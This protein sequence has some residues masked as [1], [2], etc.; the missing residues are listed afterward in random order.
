MNMK[1]IIALISL[2]GVI[3]CTLA[4]M[5]YQNQWR[6]FQKAIDENKVEDAENELTKIT[7][8]AMAHHDEETIFR[9]AIEQLRL[10]FL[11]AEDSYDVT[12]QHLDSIIALQQYQ[13]TPYAQL[14]NLTKAQFLQMYMQDN[15]G[16]IYQNDAYIRPESANILEW[17]QQKFKQSIQS[18]Y[19]F[20]LENPQTLVEFAVSEF[21]YLIDTNV[22]MRYLRPSIYDLIMQNY[23]EYLRYDNQLSYQSVLDQTIA[24][25]KKNYPSKTEIIVD[26]E[27]MYLESLAYDDKTLYMRAIDSLSAKY[28]YQPGWDA[29]IYNKAL[30]LYQY[31]MTYDFTDTATICFKNDLKTS[32]EIFQTLKTQTKRAYLKN[33]ADY[34][35]QQ[36]KTRKFQIETIKRMLPSNT[37]MLLP[38]CY[39]NMDSIYIHIYKSVNINPYWGA[40]ALYKH[41]Y[42]K[43]CPLVKSYAYKLK[44]FK[45]Y[46]QHKTDL[47][48]DGLP[49]GSYYIVMTLL[50]EMQPENRDGEIMEI[51]VTDINIVYQ[52]DDKNIKLTVLDRKT[53]MPKIKA[54]VKIIPKKNY[55]DQAKLMPTADYL[56][57]YKGQIV[58]GK[59]K[60][61]MRG[62]FEVVYQNDSLE[63]S[64]F[65]TITRDDQLQEVKSFLITDR[66]IYRP[67][68]FVF[69]KGILYNDKNKQVLNHRTITVYLQNTHYKIIDSLKLDISDFG[70]FYGQFQLPLTGGTGIY[71]LKVNE[72][73]TSFH[74]E[75]YKRPNFEVNINKIDQ[76]YILGENIAVTG[77]AQAY[78]GYPIDHATV[79]YAVTVASV[80][81][82]K[83]YVEPEFQLT[84]GTINTDQ[85]GHFTFE[86][87]S[88]ADFLKSGKLYLYKITV[89]VTDINGETQKSETSFNLGNQSLFLNMDN[90]DVDKSL[91]DSIVRV[92]QVVNI[93]GE[94]VRTNIRVTVEQLK[95]PETY[96]LKREDSY[97]DCPIMDERQYSCSF[98]GKDNQ[99]LVDIS[100]WKVMKQLYSQEISTDTLSQTVWHIK[101]WKEGMYRVVLEA[102]DKYN[103]SVK[104]TFYWNLYNTNTSSMEDYRPLVVYVSDN[105]V[106]VGE[107]LKLTV[108]SYLKKAIVYYEVKSNGVILDSGF[109]KMNQSKKNLTYNIQKA[110]CGYMTVKAFCVQDNQFY[111]VT[112]Q[113]QIPFSHQKLH[114]YTEHITNPLHP[115]SKES[116]RL[117]IKN[118]EAIQETAEVLALMYD[119]SL[120]KFASQKID[121]NP[122][123]MSEP[124]D[125]LRNIETAYLKQYRFSP[126]TS[127]YLH[128]KEYEQWHI[129]TTLYSS[130]P[131][132][133]MAKNKRAEFVEENLEF[134]SADAVAS[135]M[136]IEN[137]AGKNMENNL[138]EISLRSDFNETAFFYPNLKSDSSGSVVF[139]FTTPEQLT[140]WKFMVLSHT[141][142]L[143]TGQL[144]SLIP[145][146]KNLMLTVNRPRFLREGDSLC[147]SVKITTLKDT[148]IKG[149][150]DIEFIN[151][152]TGEEL[153]ML[154]KSSESL[155][156]FECQ[157]GESQVITWQIRVPYHLSL[158]SYRVRATSGD[159]TDGENY[160]L[161][162]LTDR[163][164]VT[165]TMPFYINGKTEKRFVFQEMISKTS[166]TITPFAYTFEY[167][168]NPIW[169]AIK[170]LPYI[171]E[172]STASNEQLFT[173]LYANTVSAYILEQNPIIQTIYEQWIQDTVSGIYS[174]LEQQG[175]LKN[176]VLEET[177]WV[178]DAASEREMQKNIAVL[179][180][181]KRLLEEQSEMI[182]RL[183]QAQNS[184]GSWSWFSGLPQ[185]SY[186]TQSILSGIGHLKSMGISVP[187]LDNMA[188]KACMYLDDEMERQYQK[189][190]N[191]IWNISAA[192]YLY[193]RSYYSDKDFLKKEFIKYYIQ[194]SRKQVFKCDL[195]TQA[196]LALSFHRFGMVKEAQNIMESIRQQA[197]KN[198]EM[199]MYWKEQFSCLSNDIERQALMIEA[200][201]EIIPNSKDIES[202]KLW[203]IKQKQT[204]SW[205]NSKST[206][207]A[208]YALLLKDT[209]LSLVDSHAVI[210]VGNYNL[211]LQT[212]EAG[213]GYLTSHWSADEITSDMATVS[214]R[215]TTS[216]PAYGASYWQ[217]FEDMDKVTASASGLSIDKKIYKV[218]ATEQGETLVEITDDEILEVGDEVVIHLLL[219]TDRNL[220][221]IHLKDMRAPAFEPI[222]VL[223]TAKYQNGL[224]YYE[225]TQDAATNFF[226]PTLNKGRY[227]FEYHLITSQK[228]EFSTGV[229]TIQSVY[230]PE[231]SAHS[232]GSRILIK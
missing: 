138:S 173:R 79:N 231:F 63:S 22:A 143:K 164:L 40:N 180:N 156:S 12:F 147:F 130:I 212:S 136:Q 166:P 95:M 177:P 119:A 123:T 141:K 51:R 20:A 8:N 209:N 116:W 139:D 90:K 204:Q 78:A 108:G 129:F 149:S 19:Q 168:S 185:S 127:G 163:M 188:A 167:T 98:P 109:V 144:E 59:T 13:K 60:E 100:R 42:S 28:Q 175:T 132:L 128:S 48:I 171:M 67:G 82:F 176:I 115:S 232:Q 107:T 145:S 33:N 5:N 120:D 34:F 159:Y 29:I 178:K 213:T 142:N 113:I 112:Q 104:D 223:S 70:S 24:F 102:K 31:G 75:N 203:L 174:K 36:I 196:L 158:I 96:I 111:Q 140:T 208:I 41:L 200:F 88:A 66:K 92:I 58:F 190:Q 131:R 152:L 215:K 16:K 153:D 230:A 160:I 91:Q 27:L 148:M 179:W 225:S 217:Y 218:E 110:Y 44:N 202:I 87:N 126:Q 151:P 94:V 184:N 68:Q 81:P 137:T 62:Y 118:T 101:S 83:F 76:E 219:N 37:P 183:E 125:Y 195:Y 15:R 50:P 85:D 133:Y 73:A 192:R 86:F 10:D 77:I 220:E 6:N 199:G 45:D 169:Y 122:Y 121:F 214:V 2:M 32:L 65:Y 124:L 117:K 64:D 39:K 1:K 43:N 134:L 155:Q 105:K 114:I 189:H 150:V 71:T 26:Y 46:Q 197:F 194:E 4:Q 69:F 55:Y 84:A 165:E 211:N 227:V 25:Y 56:T 216:G 99:A 157:V 229:T 57:D 17:N 182:N 52:E 97:P 23:L 210:R 14:L 224:W 193:A 187:G 162:V 72:A 221:Y 226:I 9:V 21:E 146:Q 61:N 49:I 172:E 18:A 206:V 201:S 74:V 89:S 3:W 93:A 191:K 228:G 7:R 30:K 53:G 207:E 181:K 135:D 198:E 106:E 47:Y 161:P 38:M 205:N 154:S 103:Q 35:I 170:A 186:I 11:Y 222:N 54:S 80:S